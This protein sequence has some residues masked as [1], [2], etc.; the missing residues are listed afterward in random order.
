VG[1]A[2]RQ[3]ESLPSLLSIDSSPPCSRTIR[4]TSKARPVPLVLVV[5]IGFEH[6]T[7][8]L[9]GNSAARVGESNDHVRFVQSVRIRKIPRLFIASKLFLIT[10]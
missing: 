8:I 4:R 2:N 9:R 5:K 6:A 1:Q 3:G 7:E 10:L